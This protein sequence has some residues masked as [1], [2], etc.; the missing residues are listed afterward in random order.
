LSNFNLG[1]P[2]TFGGGR[3]EI[4][5][6]ILTQRSSAGKCPATLQALPEGAA[7]AAMGR[8]VVAIT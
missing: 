6:Y 1:A 4:S 5:F 3:A 2:F 7:L 8:R